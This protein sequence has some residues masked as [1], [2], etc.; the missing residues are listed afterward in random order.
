MF[1]MP[2]AST[3][4]SLASPK[5]LLSSPLITPPAS[6]PASSTSA[7]DHDE[8][9]AAVRDRLSA[10]SFGRPPPPRQPSPVTESSSGGTSPLPP[11]S[12][13]AGPS[14]HFS[15]PS[16]RNS[17]LIAPRSSLSRPVPLP[18]PTTPSTKERRRHSHTRSDSISMPNLK[19][20]RPGSFGMPMTPTF[21]SS[22]NSPAVQRPFTAGN[23]NRLKF[24]PS[25]RG[26]EA[27]QAKEDY[28]RKALEKLTGGG[29]INSEP[30]ALGHEINLPELDD[31]VS[32]S[33]SSSARPLSD[34]FTN[35]N[36][37]VLLPLSPTS[38]PREESSPTW[39]PRQDEEA[40]TGLGYGSLEG[41][42]SLGLGLPT[43]MPKRPSLARNLSVLAEE[44]E[45]DGTEEEEEEEED[46]NYPQIESINVPLEAK[47]PNSPSE[48]SPFRLR[49]LFLKSET[50]TP[51]GLRSLKIA[52]S[53]TPTKYGAI[54]RGRPR[55]SPLATTES[56]STSN[57]RAR[58]SISYRKESADVSLA[59]GSGSSRW[60]QHSAQPLSPEIASPT[61]QALQ[62]P[63][64]GKGSR[65]C[66][67]PRSIIGLGSD[68][69]GAGRI[70]SD[71]Y[72]DEEDRRS[73]AQSTRVVS[74]PSRRILSKGD[75]R[76]SIEARSVSSPLGR[77]SDEVEEDWQDE[78][79]ELEMEREA[80]KEDLESWK[81]RCRALEDK[82]EVEKR[83][84]G[85]L[86]ERVRKCQLAHT[87]TSFTADAAVGDRLSAVASVSP[88]RTPPPDG[89]QVAEMRQQLFRLTTALEQEKL[90]KLDA[91]AQLADWKSHLD[92]SRLSQDVTFPPVYTVRQSPSKRSHGYPDESGDELPQ[93][94]LF[95]KSDLDTD[96]LPTDVSDAVE[97][98]EHPILTPIVTPA[99]PTIHSSSTSFVAAVDTP[100]SASSNPVA[101]ALP[102]SPLGDINLKR[103]RAWGFPSGPI[104]PAPASF[105]NKAG[106]RHSFFGLS[107]EPRRGSAIEVE[108][109]LDLPPVVSPE[110]PDD[111]D[112]TPTSTPS[113]EAQSV[114]V[115]TSAL[116]FISGYLKKS[117]DKWSI[118][119]SPPKTRVQPTSID[120][121]QREKACDGPLDFSNGCKCC[122]GEVIT[123]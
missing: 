99:T 15:V 19:L 64:R 37:L 53:A 62:S 3:L 93:W 74:S 117:P 92:R 7:L 79:L 116:S 105:S 13:P 20:G 101:P 90:E 97:P 115:T 30:L 59:S 22:P 75:T 35:R 45:T 106:N 108:Q 70:L 16:S 34:A 72:E 44:D 81:S 113:R 43:S 119:L 8:D 91:R 104:T 38:E 9:K 27:D 120:T 100:A 41:M 50:P 87:R 55:P 58:S 107:S 32:S 48:A 36:S 56:S 31:D 65:P 66:P 4:P 123:F 33:A 85:V 112:A 51:E 40:A 77:Y 10:F 47:T 94:A 54:G 73:S 39:S 63:K 25:G 57:R 18:Q 67:R 61:I 5:T 69:R 23:T 2:L 12:P 17:S 98:D 60:S 24:E 103:M 110:R 109:G 76:F 68:A 89:P 86:R 96:F 121:S 28:R 88:S 122:V 102:A 71:V 42:A 80:L 83:E 84:S 6:A 46:E 21:P 95:S 49:E 11:F 114:S 82:L 78:K 1:D 29:H 111:V 26:A 118:S 52:P 14:H